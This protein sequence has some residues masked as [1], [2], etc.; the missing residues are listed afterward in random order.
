[1]GMS[2]GVTVLLGQ[3]KINGVHQVS[4][5]AKTNEEV[6][7]LDIT[8]DEVLGVDVFHTSNLVVCAEARRHH[9]AKK[10]EKKKRSQR[11]FRTEIETYREGAYQLISEHEHSLHGELAAAIV[12]EIL[13]R[14]AEQIHDQ[15]A[16][17]TFLA[18][19]TD[20]RNTN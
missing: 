9:K 16:V 20:R 19:P 4:L 3:T 5:L 10:E 7:G 13:E 1:M 8:M 17:I 2:F 12:E 11:R 6:I 15:H 14:R 18:K